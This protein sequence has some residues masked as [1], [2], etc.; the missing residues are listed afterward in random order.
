MVLFIASPGIV[1]DAWAGPPGNTKIGGQ[2]VL[3]LISRDPPWVRCNNNMQVAV[4]LANVYRIPIQI[5]PQALAGPGVKAPAVYW[6]DELIAEDG[7]KKNGMI[8]YVEMSGIMDIE[9]VA[10][11]PTTGRA[12]AKDVKPK[13]G[14]L[15]EAIK[16]VK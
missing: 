3:T 8:S 2:K 5:I 4:E 6:G 9:G 1:T 16:D 11:H 10:M 13:H 12:M 14:A 15:K 7:G